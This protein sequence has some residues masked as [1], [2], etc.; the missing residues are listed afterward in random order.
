M[1]T[2]SSK[3]LREICAPS[4]LPFIDKRNE[5]FVFHFCMQLRWYETPPYYDVIPSEKK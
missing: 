2:K 1:W 4:T 3:G 5:E